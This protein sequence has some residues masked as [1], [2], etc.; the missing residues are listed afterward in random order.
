[1]A[2]STHLGCHSPDPD[3]AL[4]PG[5]TPTCCL[6]D[7]GDPVHPAGEHRVAVEHLYLHPL[8]HIL[9]LVVEWDLGGMRTRDSELPGLAGKGGVA[10]RLRSHRIL[11][12]LTVSADSQAQD[13]DEDE[14]GVAA[15]L[16]EQRWNG[17]R[18]GWAR[19]RVRDPVTQP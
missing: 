16:E 14:P 7:R 5:R 2:L 8:H 12:L 1:M 6:D 3:P 9:P 4:A 18:S 13:K 11:R 10:S 19:V 17:D 15:V